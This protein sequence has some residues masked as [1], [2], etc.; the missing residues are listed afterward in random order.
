MN[1]LKLNA[2]LRDVKGTGASRQL[3]RE[4]IVPAQLY[5]RDKENVNLQ[6]VA[7]ELDKIIVEAGTSTIISLVIDGEDHKVLIRDYQRHPYKNQYLHVDFLGVNLDE[8][9]R[10][11]VPVVLLNRDEIYVQPSV[12]MQHLEEIEI[13]ALPMDIPSHVE[14]DV[15]TMEYDDTFYVKDL[16]V[17]NNDKVEVLTDLEEAVVTLSEP[18]EEDLDEEVEDVDAADVEVIG[19]SEEEE[20][21][22][23]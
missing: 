12:L 2:Q 21:E 4:N 7:K 13:E 3:R 18:V 17:V 1:E 22:E 8:K 15:Q 20:S 9:L 16:E 6:V 19:E 10:V 5:Q 23:E 14:L 11:S